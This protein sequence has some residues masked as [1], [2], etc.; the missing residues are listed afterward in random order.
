MP[1]RNAKNNPIRNPNFVYRLQSENCKRE[2]DAEKD[3][4]IFVAIASV[5]KDPTNYRK[6][7][8]SEDRE[9]GKP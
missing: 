9:G 4:R 5:N 7:M 6:A 1:G 3:E 8:Q 2:N